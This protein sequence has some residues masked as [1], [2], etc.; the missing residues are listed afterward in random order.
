MVALAGTARADALVLV[1]EGATWQVATAVAPAPTRQ[2]AAVALGGLDVA[3]G[4]RTD[5]VS[6]FGDDAV[7]AAPPAWPLGNHG[8]AQLATAPIA[9]EPSPE[10]RVAVLWAT[11]RFRLEGASDLRVLDLR[12]RYGDGL[13]VWLNGIEIA[14]RRIP[15]KARPLAVAAVIHGPEWETFHIPVVPGLLRSGD[16]VLAVEVRP[17]AAS[18]A[19]RL[20]LSLI[21]RPAAALVRG[22]V[23]Q[24]VSDGGAT[25]V[26]ET[27][28]PSTAAVEFGRDDDLGERVEAPARARR[29]A[30]HLDA[31]P[32]SAPVHYRVVVDGAATPIRVFRTLP[33][34]GEV[35]R[36]AVYGDVRGG[37]ETHAELLARIRAE[38]PDLVVATGD[39]VLRG[40]DEGD[41]Q[42]FFTVAGDLLATIPFW[43]APGNHDLGR[44]GD[45]HRLFGD[46]F[47]VPP[48]PERPAWASWSSFDAGD[49]HVAL[50]DS[51]AYNEPAQLAWLDADL[52]AA[53]AGGARVL[54]AFT[55]D[56]P[57][58][59]GTHG[60]NPV[61]ASIYVPVL[62]KYG[63]A[64][65][66]SGHDHLY[67][68]GRMGGLDYLVS[69]GGGAPLYAVSCG[70]RGRHAC[71]VDDGMIAVAPEHH[72]VM[73][74]AYPDSL[75]ACARHADGSA[76]EPCVRY[77][78]RMPPK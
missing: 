26:V 25:I 24:N 16:N 10:E 62:V 67:Q 76:V 31:L 43:S 15:R 39:L 75:E 13:V 29:H 11:T 73:L 28:L 68:R 52:K 33:G 77:P 49:V 59:R 44:T 64:L 55:H 57:Y 17:S 36:L 1:P 23:L 69:G 61:A 45:D 3:A 20:D 19:P 14:R 51:N 53:R 22:P 66:V 12:A 18:R 27:D 7:A 47:G 56:G 48:T 2:L 5:G 72:Y 9:F 30:L 74:T 54:L 65:I 8:R 63:V 21:A 40:S 71:A 50:L 32:R 6:I 37:H 70:V 35:V 60:G 42:R 38:D 34:R 58:S 78:L 41:W 4:R 46:V